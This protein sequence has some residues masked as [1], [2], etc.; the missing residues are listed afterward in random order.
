MLQLT[1]RDGRR[2][3]LAAQGRSVH[4]LRAP[5]TEGERQAAVL[6]TP[7]G[8]LLVVTGPG[9]GYLLPPL[10]A[11][12]GVTVL[13]VEQDGVLQVP[14]HPR[15]RRVAPARAATALA[16]GVREFTAVQFARGP[17][18]KHDPAY[19][20]AETALRQALERWAGETVTVGAFRE[21]WL[22]NFVAQARLNPSLTA[23][24]TRATGDTAVIAAA[25]PSL[26]EAAE[27]LRQWRGTLWA[28]D[29]AWPALR[30]MGVTPALVV[31]N[32]PQSV[33]AKHFAD[34]VPETATLLTT[35]TADPGVAKKFARRLYY[36]DGYPLGAL[37][38]CISGAVPAFSHAGGSAVMILYQL[39]AV[40]GAKRVVMLGQDL[41]YPLAGES[42]AAGSVYGE[43]ALGGLH[44]Y[45]TLEGRG[46]RDRGRV[47]VQGMSGRVAV[48]PPMA[49]YRQW[50]EGFIA[51]HPE[52]EFINTATRGV[53]IAGCTSGLCESIAQYDGMKMNVNV[54]TRK[55]RWHERAE[56]AAEN[57]NN[58]L[59]CRELP[60]IETVREMLRTL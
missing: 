40:S 29:T 18:F 7:P 44:R 56:E 8:T 25:G 4:S 54:D 23:W 9:L 47:I 13:A 11:R 59:P 45:N 60:S 26:N 38:P 30:R 15:L 2:V 1:E 28:V 33:S 48:T 5:E 55:C 21:L 42:H 52:I 58:V 49:Q 27:V 22:R 43:Q 17:A 14:A 37:F 53:T 51:D 24:R 32:D 34:A 16:E 57:L 46:A 12:D 41:A 31:S 6:T 10:L 36:D 35:F 20:A 50:L 19:A 39:A 3:L